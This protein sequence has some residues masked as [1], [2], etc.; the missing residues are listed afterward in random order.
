MVS[1][2]VAF[3]HHSLLVNPS[4][5]SYS[6]CAPD[7]APTASF[8]TNSALLPVLILP[9]KY[10]YFCVSVTNAAST[11]DTAMVRFECLLN[12]LP[13]YGKVPDMYWSEHI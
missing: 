8:G 6:L 13:P 2:L 7:D 11:D 12:P 4:V 1:F 3:I 5:F 10:V 9:G